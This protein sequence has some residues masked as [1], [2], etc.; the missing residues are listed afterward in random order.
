MDHDAVRRAEPD[1]LFLLPDV[2]GSGDAMF[3]AIGVPL[4]PENGSVA[5][6]RAAACVFVVGRPPVGFARI[7][8]VDGSAHLEQLSVRP[9]H[10]GR[11]LGAALLAATLDWAREQGFGQVTLTT[12]PDV[13]WNGPFYRRRGFVPHPGP[14]PELRGIRDREVAAGLDDH[15]R[16]EVLVH[17]LT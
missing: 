1:D 9:E 13:A 12:F 8:V 16:R 15:A 17:H 7:D 6:L 10:G 4:P 11:G 2:E 5:D 14:G 3:E